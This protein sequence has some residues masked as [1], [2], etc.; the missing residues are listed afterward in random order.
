MYNNAKHNLRSRHE[1][2]RKFLGLVRYRF[3]FVF[4]NQKQNMDTRKGSFQFSVV[5]FQ[6]QTFRI[7]MTTF[8]VILPFI[9]Y[10][11]FIHETEN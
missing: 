2:T 6:N 5:N 10:D 4:K 11:F 7:N 3:K 1:Y 8:K 9:P